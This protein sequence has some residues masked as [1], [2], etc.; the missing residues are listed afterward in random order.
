MIFPSIPT[1]TSRSTT[2]KIYTNEPFNGSTATTLDKSEELIFDNFDL[3]T[4]YSLIINL[5]NRGK[6]I[7]FF[8][9][10]TDRDIE[11]IRLLAEIPEDG[12]GGGGGQPSIIG[13]YDLDLS[14]TSTLTITGTNFTASTVFAIVGGSGVVSVDSTNFINDTTVE[15]TLTSDASTSIYTITATNGALTSPEIDNLNVRNQDAI[16]RALSGQSLIDYNL[17]LAGE[18]VAITDTEWNNLLIEVANVQSF[19]TSDADLKTGAFGNFAGGAQFTFGQTTNPSAGG[20]YVFAFKCGIGQ[21]FT[22]G[23]DLVRL[24]DNGATNWLQFGNALP[25]GTVFNR[26]QYYVLKSSSIPTASPSYVGLTTDS[27]ISMYF[28]ANNTN[29][30]RISGSSD[31]PNQSGF[32]WSLQCLSTN[33]IQW[34]I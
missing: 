22:G 23:N 30:L 33:T 1:V 27:T 32:G 7:W 3:S 21:A 5:T 4:W 19:G 16:F 13:N 2:P 28:N 18:W 24:S 29:G 9:N 26:V 17:A 8:A 11:Y 25:D 34:I 6:V 15:V 14:T 31:N 20:Q 10:A 12:G